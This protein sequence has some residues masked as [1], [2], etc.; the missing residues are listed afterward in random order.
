MWGLLCVNVEP[1]YHK[2]VNGVGQ[3]LT[4]L[5]FY[6]PLQAAGA[7]PNNYILALMFVN[8]RELQE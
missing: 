1:P 8:V 4:G 5:C 7:E 3:A 2:C 6:Q